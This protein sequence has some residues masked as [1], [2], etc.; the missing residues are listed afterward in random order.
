MLG[1][2]ESEGEF[3]WS[4]SGRVLLRFVP[5]EDCD[6]G[7]G[8][9]CFAVQDCELFVVLGR[10]VPTVGTTVCFGCFDEV[11]EEFEGFG[12]AA[13]PFEVFDCVDPCAE[14]FAFV[15]AGFVCHVRFPCAAGLGQ[16][17]CLRVRG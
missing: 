6:F 8:L 11:A 10:D 13:L 9:A 4:C 15:V 14:M 17:L 1:L 7:L 5:F 12:V 16:I 3:G 2:L